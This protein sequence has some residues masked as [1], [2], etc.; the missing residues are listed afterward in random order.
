[1]NDSEQYFKTLPQEVPDLVKILNE[2]GGLLLH[3]ENETSIKVTGKD[4]EEVFAAKDVNI[5]SFLMGLL[6]GCAIQDLRKE[7]ETSYDHHKSAN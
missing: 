7:K 1:M 4:F 6:L 2:K 5:Q 3:S